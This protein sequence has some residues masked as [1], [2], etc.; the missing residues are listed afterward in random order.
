MSHAMAAPQPLCALEPAEPQA[1]EAE[2]AEAMDAETMAVAEEEPPQGDLRLVVASEVDEAELRPPMEAEGPAP[3]SMDVEMQASP[4]QGRRAGRRRG[5]SPM[6]RLLGFRRRRLRVRYPLSFKAGVIGVLISVLLWVQHVVC[7]VWPMT[8]VQTRGPCSYNDD[9]LRHNARMIFAYFVIFIV[10][11]IS[12]L[13][14]PAAAQIAEAH[15][16]A[17]GPRRMYVIH[18]VVHGPLYVFSIGSLLF[19]VQLLQYPECENMSPALYHVL[20]RHAAYSCLVSGLCLCLSYWHSR[21]LRQAWQARRRDKRRAPPDTIAKLATY[22]YDEA[23]F[24]DEEGKRFPG[25]CP[26]CLSEW[27]PTD[28]IKLTPCGHVFHEV[29]L[30]S[31]LRTERTCALCRQDVCRS[32]TG[33]TP[34]SF[35]EAA[36][37]PEG[38]TPDPESA[39]TLPEPQLVGAP[40]LAEALPGSSIPGLETR[41]YSL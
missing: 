7:I 23:A 26:I 32:C 41:T 2:A 21:L 37:Q 40:S 38:R 13:W 33:A 34:K 30:A 6:R 3:S 24:G 11:R 17:L 35:T 20:K 27:E 39:S 29:C 31:W 12:S 25:E 5:R 10:V 4:H 36:Q 9:Q 28:V 8:A 22:P 15:A 16:G 1:S 19:W 14:P 18:L